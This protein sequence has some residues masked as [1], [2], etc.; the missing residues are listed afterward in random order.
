MASTPPLLVTL[1]VTHPF[2]RR[3]G[4]SALETEYPSHEAAREGI[5]QV[6][7]DFYSESYP[8]IA[9]ERPQAIASA[10]EALGDIYCWNV[11][12][13]MNVTW[14]TYP[15]HIGHPD[16]SA[17]VGCFRCHGG[18]H[19]TEEGDTISMDCTTCHSVLAQ[20]EEEPEILAAL[21]D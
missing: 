1:P 9:A 15:S 12:P 13:T 5:A 8:D 3:E 19:A 17:E 21:Q 14:G 16:M 18:E 10:G 20:E 2:I 4:L 11:F 7:T 6:I